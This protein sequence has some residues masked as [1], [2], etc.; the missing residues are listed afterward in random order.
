MASNA[1]I[2]TVTTS[3]SSVLLV[4][5]PLSGAINLVWPTPDCLV[6][7]VGSK[8][9]KD[10]SS[11]TGTEVVLVIVLF[12]IA[13]LLLMLLANRIRSYVYREEVSTCGICTE[14][15]GQL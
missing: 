5:S 2:S 11:L 3:S 10:T 7:V 8:S 1:T 15:S 4:S 6:M 12:G 9:M 13:V 14:A